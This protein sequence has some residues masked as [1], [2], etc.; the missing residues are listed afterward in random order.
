MSWA[1]VRL[2]Y[3]L[4]LL[5]AFAFYGTYCQNT[6][7]CLHLWGKILLLSPR[8]SRFGSFWSSIHTLWFHSSVWALEHMVGSEGKSYTGLSGLTTQTQ[9]AF[10]I[11]VPCPTVKFT[12]EPFQWSS[13]TGHPAN[14]NRSTRVE[15]Q[16]KHIRRSSLLLKCLQASFLNII[17]F[18][19]PS[20]TW[21]LTHI[22]GTLELSTNEL[23][24]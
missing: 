6:A 23:Q 24:H 13:I 4:F 21:T 5:F 3:F 18:Q 14:D 16:S 17:S 15:K 1:T 20:E 7:L 11:C 12:P 9:A 10:M 2:K 19:G 8:F 22:Q